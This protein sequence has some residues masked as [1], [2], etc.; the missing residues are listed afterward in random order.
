M[1]IFKHGYKPRVP[2][3]GSETPNPEESFPL[4]PVWKEHEENEQSGILDKESE[5]DEPLLEKRAEM[6]AAIDETKEAISELIKVY[7]GVPDIKQLE[8]ED[9]WNLM[10]KMVKASEA[11]SKLKFPNNLVKQAEDHAQR[12]KDFIQV[13]GQISG[14]II[15]EHFIDE[16]KRLEN[17]A[18]P[19]LAL[20]EK[21]A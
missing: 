9:K 5:E 11:M 19:R 8:P 7:M 18:M 12:M 4:P 16:A 20:D 2:K 14:D 17:E 21:A 10:E 15:Q 1:L 3:P 6:R 13:K